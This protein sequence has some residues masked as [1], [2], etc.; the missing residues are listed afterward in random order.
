MGLKMAAFRRASGN[1]M[2]WTL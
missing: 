2:S 1:L